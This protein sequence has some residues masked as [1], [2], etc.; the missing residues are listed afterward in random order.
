MRGIQRTSIRVS[1]SLNSLY[2]VLLPK[3]KI[4]IFKTPLKWD[5]HIPS[6]HEIRRVMKGAAA[7]AT[8]T[9]NNDENAGRH[10]NLALP[11]SKENIETPPSTFAFVRKP[12]DCTFRWVLCAF[13]SL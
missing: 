1:E 10:D 13:F 8:A 7:T 11:L 4:I 12:Y 6:T 3:K 5:V 2:S 9:A